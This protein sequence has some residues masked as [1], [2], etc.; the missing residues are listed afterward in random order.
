MRLTVDAV[1]FSYIDETLHVLLIKRNFEPFLNC[2]SLPGAF[3]NENETTDEAVKRML[4][5]ETNI[6][7]DYL[8]QLYT[9]S[10]VN[11]DPRERIVSV[12]YY[13]LIKSTKHILKISEHA[14]EVSWVEVGDAVTRDLAFD[15][16]EILT[17]A[18]QRLRNKIQYEPIGFDLLPTYF[19]MGELHKLYE[20]VYGREID[21]RNFNKK[22]IGTGLLKKTTFKNNPKV[23]RKAILYEFD[24]N[25]YSKLKE[26]GYNLDL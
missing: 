16:H 12:A 13:A 20:V 21:R 3:V 11:R 5:N 25:Q 8:E 23:G 1:V 4:K 19:T 15:H 18:I 7:L 6:E 24:L 22:L 10:D 14:T 17:Y 26:K 9:F 2:Y